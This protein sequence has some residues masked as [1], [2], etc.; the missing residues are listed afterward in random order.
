MAEDLS[1]LTR[2]QLQDRAMSKMRLQA[3]LLREENAELYAV[4]VQ[5]L[6]DAYDDILTYRDLVTIAEQDVLDALAAVEEA[7]KD[8]DESEAYAKEAEYVTVALDLLVIEAN[9]K[10][11]NLKSNVSMILMRIYD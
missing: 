11:E 3:R 7:K 8:A 5:P 1:K 4:N 10:V 2:R 9:D 6:A